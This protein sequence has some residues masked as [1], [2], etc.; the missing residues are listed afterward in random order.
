[1]FVLYLF[2]IKSQGGT[3]CSLHFV[4]RE[5]ESWTEVLFCQ[6]TESTVTHSVGKLNIAQTLPPKTVHSAERSTMLMI[7]VREDMA[8]STWIIKRANLGVS[9]SE[10][11]NLLALMKPIKASKKPQKA[12]ALL[13]SHTHFRSVDCWPDQNNKA[14][15][16]PQSWQHAWWEQRNVAATASYTHSVAPQDWLKLLFVSAAAKMIPTSLPCDM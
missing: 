4:R 11:Q 5:S 7:N 15:F 10:H 16:S 12:E 13:L 14:P 8:V 9:C 2:C 1:M 3:A 6:W